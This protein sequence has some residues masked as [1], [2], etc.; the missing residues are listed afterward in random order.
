MLPRAS[1]ELRVECQP[2]KESTTADPPRKTHNKEDSLEAKARDR[3]R[4]RAARRTSLPP[5]DRPD[6]AHHRF[7]TK[8]APQSQYYA[9]FTEPICP[10]PFSRLIYRL[11]ALYLGDLHPM[12]IRNVATHPRGLLL[13]FKGPR[14]RSVHHHNCGI[15]RVPNPISLLVI[16]TRTS[17]WPLIIL[18]DETS[19]RFAEKRPSFRY[20]EG[21]FGGHQLLD[22]SSRLSPLPSFDYR[23]ALQNRYDLHYG[24]PLLRSQQA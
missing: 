20:P 2:K 19:M 24:F 6:E 11:E 13:G 21:V 5:S 14:R 16:S 18:L 10:L 12:W 9:E 1:S 22:G 15:L 3:A 23:F 4:I 8:P 7:R 17:F